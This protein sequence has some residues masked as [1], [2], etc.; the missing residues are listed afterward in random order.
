MLLVNIEGDHIQALK[1]T[2]QRGSFRGI[3]PNNC[4]QATH[5]ALL[6]VESFVNKC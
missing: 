5:R 3:F 6:L 4:V 1:N 2:Q